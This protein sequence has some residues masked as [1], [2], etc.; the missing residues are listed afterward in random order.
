MPSPFTPTEQR[1][2]DLLDDGLPHRREELHRC[3][4]DELAALSAIQ[5]HLSRLRRRLNPKGIDILCILKDRTLHY[6]KIRVCYSAN[7]GRT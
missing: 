4:S 1:I 6:Q 2:M 3:L 7:D 5:P